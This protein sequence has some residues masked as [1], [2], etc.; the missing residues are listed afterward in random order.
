[1]DLKGFGDIAN[2]VSCISRYGLIAVALILMLPCR[3]EARGNIINAKSTSFADVELAVSRASSGDTVIIPA[4][5]SS[6][7]QTLK[8]TKAITLLGST[9]VSG[10]HNTAMAADDL[11][12]IVDDVPIGAPAG[13]AIIIDFSCASGQSGRISGITFR[14]GSRTA[15]PNLGGVVLSGNSDQVRV[16]HCH[17]DNLH[18]SNLT[19][20]GVLHGVIDHC[21]FNETNFAASIVVINGGGEYGDEAWTQDA[22][23]GSGNFMFIEDCTFSWLGDPGK[24]NACGLDSYHGGRY[25]ARYCTFNNSKPNTHGTDSSGRMR[26]SRA[27]EIYGNKLNWTRGYSPTGGQL[28]GGGL[29]IHD[30]IYTNYGSGYGL[31]VYRAFFPFLFGGAF[32]TNPWDSNDPHGVYESGTHDGANR[33]T[34]LTE[35]RAN[36]T[37]NQWVGY[38]IM[39][40]VTGRGSYI[41]SST[42]DT[43]TYAL[44]SS[45]GSEPNLVFNN[46]DGFEVRKLLV[47]LDQP[48]RGKGE[49]LTGDHPVNAKTGTIAWP[50]QTLEPVYSWN[51]TNNGKNLDVSTYGD[52]TLIGG[53][54][55]YNRTPMPGYVPYTYPHPL[56][57]GPSLSHGPTATSSPGFANNLHKTKAWAPKLERKEGKKIKEDSTNKIAK[58]Q[59][60]FGE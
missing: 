12:I 40:T 5:T 6:W 22:Q 50:H 59:G 33:A 1:M 3:V 4:G 55:Y 41:T 31:H 19:I 57:T 36:W 26:S 58:D 27:V 43:I 13:R 37:P 35:S 17:F 32:G 47:A 53:R 18:S 23:F 39:N 44:D 21:F 48:G 16:D 54:D 34:A 38:S 8:V 60:T 9:V 49:L 11:T 7:S 52:P 10:D 28:R 42:R 51:N 56:T 30:N 15:S 20:G 24:Q 14:A 46:G 2:R 25:V 45:Y 29:L